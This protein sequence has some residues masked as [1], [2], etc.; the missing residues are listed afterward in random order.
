MSTLTLDPLV[1][2]YTDTRICVERLLAEYAVH[3]KLIIACDFDDTVFDF[4]KQGNRYDAVINALRYCRN[5]GFHIVLFTGTHF[6]QWPTQV[7]YLR[8]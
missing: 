7:E 5:L 2:P 8:K 3:K 1:D 6:D 4:H